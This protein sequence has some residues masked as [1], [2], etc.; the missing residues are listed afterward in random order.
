MSF[1]EITFLPVKK[2]EILG[3]ISG[4]NFGEFFGKFVSNFASFSET[5]FSRRA[6]LTN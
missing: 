3:R 5:S 6:M 2:L 1:G 4:G